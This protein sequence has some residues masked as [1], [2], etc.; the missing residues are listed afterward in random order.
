MSIP[1]DGFQRAAKVTSPMQCLT[2]AELQEALET[3]LARA[4]EAVERVLRT[5]PDCFILDCAVFVD[6]PS[7]NISPR[8]VDGTYDVV[9]QVNLSRD[10]VCLYGR[11]DTPI[12]PEPGLRENE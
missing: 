11:P 10:G 3:G 9:L 2:L 5:A 6:R 7:M 1:I 8:N 4:A 12:G